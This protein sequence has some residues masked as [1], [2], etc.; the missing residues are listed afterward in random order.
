[1]VVVLRMI[2]LLARG[3]LLKL[4]TPVIGRW[5]PTAAISLL[6]RGTSEMNL[7]NTVTGAARPVS[8]GLAGTGAM[9]EQGG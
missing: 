4:A 1:M 3:A 5:R 2:M 8:L 6:S 7:R 9:L